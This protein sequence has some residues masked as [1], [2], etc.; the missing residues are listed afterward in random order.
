MVFLAARGGVVCPVSAEMGRGRS[1]PLL[2]W[3][4]NQGDAN[5]PFLAR[6]LTRG[7]QT[8]AIVAFLRRRFAQQGAL[9]LPSARRG[10]AGSG[11]INADEIE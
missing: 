2:L 6:T 4:A 3:P 5:G 8:L 10:P 1:S 11:G 9:L 7:R